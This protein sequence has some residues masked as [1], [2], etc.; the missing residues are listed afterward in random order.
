VAD[1]LTLDDLK[2]Y[3]GNQDSDHDAFLDLML[4]VVETMLEGKTG[5][6]FAAGGAVTDE[7]QDGKGT[8]WLYLD[9]PPSAVSA[10]KVGQDVSDPDDT[11]DVADIVVDQANSRLIYLNSRIFPKGIR[12]IFVTYTA[13]ENLPALAKAAV[14]EGTTYLYR[15]RGREHITGESLGEL[16]TIN[17]MNARL[18]RLPVWQAAIMELSPEFV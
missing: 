3:L 9:R 1:L 10:I 8:P 12:N 17:L 14:M 2:S 11:I 4:D 13:A 18:E 7:P 6:N 15:R 16:G 5:Q